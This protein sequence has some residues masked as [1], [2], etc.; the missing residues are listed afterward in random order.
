MA[1]RGFTIKHLLS[2]IGADLNLPPL[3]VVRQ[4]SAAEVTEGRSIAS[5]RIHMERA[6][7]H[8]KRFRVLSGT[9]RLKMYQL[10]DQIVTVCAY[11]Q[12]ARVPTP[13]ETVSDELLPSSRP[14]TPVPCTSLTTPTTGDISSSDVPISEL[15]LSSCNSGDDLDLDSSGSVSA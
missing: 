14:P 8:M 4:F 15:D 13:K 12:P 6:I 11:F 3:L 9:I 2:A 1:D 10:I 5:L 7:G